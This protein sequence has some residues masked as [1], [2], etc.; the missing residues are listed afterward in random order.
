MDSRIAL[1]LM[2]SGD[3]QEL[4]RQECLQASLKHGFQ[5]RCYCADNDPKKQAD[6]IESCLAE[7]PRQRPNVMLISPV[8]E[9]ALLTAAHNATRAGVGWVLLNRWNDYLSVLRSEFPDL[10]IFCV[11]ADQYE[12]GRI[13]ARQFRALL[14][15]GGKLVY[16]R[17]PLG[18]SSVMRRFAG[19]EQGLANTSI[20]MF[21]VNSDWTTEGG[22]RAMSEWIG[23]FRGQELPAF[24]VGAQ[25]DCMGMGAHRALARVPRPGWGRGGRFVVTG[26]DGSP[27]FGRRLA[28]EGKLAATVIIPV[29]AA[30]AIA[31][32]A[33]MRRGGGRPSAE[34]LLSPSSYPPLDDLARLAS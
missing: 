33:A 2:N 3:Y 14:P 25:N 21:T 29:V 10:P 31:E 27:A 4:L 6:Q 23:M 11:S 13:Q 22:E 34:I 26:C 9:G 12:I 7:P 5:V 8:R 30:R 24:V 18:T 28:S 1:F 17:G 20:R 16:I 15:H 32:I 19:V